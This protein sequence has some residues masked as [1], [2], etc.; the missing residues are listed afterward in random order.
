MAFTRKYEYPRKEKDVLGIAPRRRLY[1]TEEEYATYCKGMAAVADQWLKNHRNG[2]IR[3]FAFST[4]EYD[5]RI[6][7]ADIASYMSER[8]R[9]EF[10]AYEENLSGFMNV[11]FRLFQ[12]LMKQRCRRFWMK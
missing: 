9:M 2:R 5:D 10:I 6:T 1:S 11:G 3:F 12:F 7:A 8:E 4:G